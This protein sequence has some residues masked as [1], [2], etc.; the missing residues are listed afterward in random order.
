MVL[1]WP[2]QAGDSQITEA[3]N[4]E[5]KRYFSLWGPMHWLPI[6]SFMPKYFLLKPRTFSYLTSI[7]VIGFR[8]F[9]IDAVLFNRTFVFSSP[10]VLSM[11]FLAMI[12]PFRV[13]YC[14]QSSRLFSCF[15]CGAAFFVL[16]NMDISGVQACGFCRMPPQSHFPDNFPLLL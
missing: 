5:K 16:C 14:I 11:S 15:E 1:V 4:E 7:Q 12:F 13:M 8:E 6:P 3:V 10:Q 2:Q 9:D